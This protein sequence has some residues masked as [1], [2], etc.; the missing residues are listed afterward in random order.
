MIAALAL[1]IALQNAPQLNMASGAQVEGRMIL[2]GI[3]RPF[4]DCTSQHAIA[5]MRHRSIDDYSIPDLSDSRV[6]QIRREVANACAATRQEAA[7]RLDQLLLGRPD[8]SDASARRAA[9]ELLLLYSD[10]TTDRMIAGYASSQSGE[11]VESR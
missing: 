11:P 5:A 8:F 6:S 1:A 7:S 3:V 4:Q 10:R 9:I 2:A